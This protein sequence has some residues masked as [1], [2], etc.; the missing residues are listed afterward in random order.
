MFT[1]KKTICLL[2]ATIVIVS[3]TLA[4]A[5]AMPIANVLCPSCSTRLIYDGQYVIGERNH[6]FVEHYD[7]NGNYLHDDFYYEEIVEDLYYCPSCVRW[8]PYIS[9]R[10]VIEHDAEG[11]GK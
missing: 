10:L 8:H 6:H 4:T 9:Y 1:M 2:L 5:Q 11:L 7:S 3:L